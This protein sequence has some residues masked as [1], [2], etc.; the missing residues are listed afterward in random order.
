MIAIKMPMPK[1]C[2]IE[3]KKCPLLNDGMDCNLQP[4]SHDI[5]TFSEQFKHCPLIDMDKY[6]DDLK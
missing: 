6:Q 1:N 2:H 3:K 5:K 4:E